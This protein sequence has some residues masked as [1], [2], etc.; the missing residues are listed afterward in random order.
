MST[1]VR[2]VLRSTCERAVDGSGCGEVPADMGFEAGAS[3]D[4]PHLR[5]SLKGELAERGRELEDD[6]FVD[7]G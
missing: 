6:A 7:C 2:K 4:P 1:G 5:S 3:P